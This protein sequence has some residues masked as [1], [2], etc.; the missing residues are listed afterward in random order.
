MNSTNANVLDDELARDIEAAL[1]SEQ[2]PG[3]PDLRQLYD[4]AGVVLH[5]HVLRRYGEVE[6]F[7]RA[8]VSNRRE[9]LNTELQDT[10]SRITARRDDIARKSERRRF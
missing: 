4:E 1:E 9:H 6:Q 10:R 3:I 2:P 5:E 8:V 7:H